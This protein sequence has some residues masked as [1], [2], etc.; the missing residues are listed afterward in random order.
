MNW[1]YIKE[2]AREIKLLKKTLSH[3][4]LSAER[5]SSLPAE[6]PMTKEERQDQYE[7]EEYEKLVTQV[8]K[9]KQ[10]RQQEIENDKKWSKM[11]DEIM[12]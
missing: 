8:E 4:S 12:K 5:H 7:D 1:N 9:I 6:Q 10:K 2:T 11:N 3:D